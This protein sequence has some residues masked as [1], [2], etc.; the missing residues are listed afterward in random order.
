[1]KPDVL[2]EHYYMSA[3]RSVHA[4]ANHYDKTD[5]NGPKIFVGEWA[6]REGA[7]TPNMAA[8][9]GD[10]AWMTG[11]ERNSD[12]VI[13]ACYAPLFVNVNPGGM[14][15][16]TDLIGYDALSSYGSPSYWAQVM[17]AGH[18]GNRGRRHIPRQRRSAHRRIRHRDEKQRK[19]FIKVVNGT[20]ERQRFQIALDGAPQS[21]SQATLVTMSGKSPN[22]TNTHHP[23]PDNIKPV[24]KHDP[25]RRTNVRIQLCA[26]FGQR[27]RDELLGEAVEWSWRARLVCE[28]KRQ[29]HGGKNQPPHT[30]PGLRRLRAGRMPLGHRVLFRPAGAERDERGAHGALPLPVCL[31]GHAARGA[32]EPGA[33]SRAAR[34]K[35]LL[36]SAGLGVPIQFLMQFH[37]LARTTVSHASL[38]VGSMPV[39]LAAA[40][41]LFAGERLDWSAGRRWLRPPSVRH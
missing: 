1:M 38:M 20:S 13:M 22:A 29:G 33:V 36:V 12:M 6:T 19:L 10:A 4:T 34:F 32:D 39:M 23:D 3:R 26:L 31:R 40:A 41:A 14:Q 2:D 5:R 24:E 37:G 27:D 11:M 16:E 15:W 9:L 28:S 17:F 21:G 35:M 18:T 7:P 8:A 30:V 25:D